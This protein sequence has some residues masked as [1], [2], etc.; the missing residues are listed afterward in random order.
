MLEQGADAL[1]PTALTGEGPLLDVEETIGV[2][3]AN[4]LAS[5][6]HREASTAANIA[7]YT[8]Q[9]GSLALRIPSVP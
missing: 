7:W 1:M 6:S 3:D 2:W 8:S 5:D 9:Y 4:L